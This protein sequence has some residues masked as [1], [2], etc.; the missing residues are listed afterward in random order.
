MRLDNLRKILLFASV[1]LLTSCSASAVHAVESNSPL[2][3]P[4]SS[5]LPSP[6]AETFTPQFPCVPAGTLVQEGTVEWVVDGDTVHV[7]VDGI[8]YRV[9]YIGVDT[10]EV[11]EPGGEEATRYNLELVGGQTV[12]LVKDV[13]EVDKYGRLLRYVFVGDT[14]VNY[15]LVS[16]GFADAGVWEPD[17]ACGEFLMSAESQAKQLGLGIWK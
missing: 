5:P 6:T 8:S 13:S 7:D 3:K 2:P 15:A 16:N 9:R 14:F 4:S 1:L 12:T 17:S 10:P 11:D